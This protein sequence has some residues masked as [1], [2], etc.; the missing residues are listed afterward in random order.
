MGSC[1]ALVS[2][3]VSGNAIR[4]IASNCVSIR[5]LSKSRARRV[6]LK[7]SWTPAQPFAALNVDAAATSGPSEFYDSSPNGG[8]PLSAGIMAREL[9]T[10]R[11]MSRLLIVPEVHAELARLAHCIRAL[12]LQFCC[13]PELVASLSELILMRKIPQLGKRTQRRDVRG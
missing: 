7:T 9:R 1:W 6:L 2:V 10:S 3:S 8:K 5:Y 13:A 11:R 4:A 12:L